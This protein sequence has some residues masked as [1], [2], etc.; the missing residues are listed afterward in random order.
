MDRI[1]QLVIKHQDKFKFLL[2]A[3]AAIACLNTLAR[4]DFNIIL[5]L[6]VYYVWHNMADSKEAQ[7]NEKINS[8]FVFLFSLL[9]DFIWVFFWGSRW[10][11]KND[12][13]AFVHS[14]VIFFSWI[15][16][17]LKVFD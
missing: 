12:N 13:E 16:I 15:G 3:G 14:F 10:G 5:Y 7:T 11:D 4:A 2:F 6:Y 17:L 9:I 8:F 1:K